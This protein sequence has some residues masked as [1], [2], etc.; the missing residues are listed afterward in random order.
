[1]RYLIVAVVTC[2]LL[3]PALASAQHDE[4]GSPSPDRFRGFYGGARAAEVLGDR[5]KATGYY[6]KLLE[7]AQ[8]ADTERPELRHARTFVASRN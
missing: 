6:E 3:R 8:D 2:V 4:H 1:M 5:A 7:V